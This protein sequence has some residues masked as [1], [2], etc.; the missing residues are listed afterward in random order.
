M[1]GH[2]KVRDRFS[3]SVSKNALSHAH[4]IIGEDGIGKSLLADEFAY[5]ILGIPSQRTC[6][7]C[8][9]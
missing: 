3:K 6:R 2:N 1:I 9:L 4:L 8:S 5:K 7:Y